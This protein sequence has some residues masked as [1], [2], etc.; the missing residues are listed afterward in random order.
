MRGWEEEI[1]LMAKIVGKSFVGWQ[2]EEVSTVIWI[3]KEKTLEVRL[4]V[5]RD[6]VNRGW[7]IDLRAG[8]NVKPPF[9]IVCCPVQEE[10]DDVE[11]GNV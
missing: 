8:G 2:E 4:P 11:I 3:S 7:E 10:A 9:S 1:Y 6:Y 5:T